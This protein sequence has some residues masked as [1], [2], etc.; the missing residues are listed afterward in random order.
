MKL[1]LRVLGLS[2]LPLI[3]TGCVRA[4]ALTAFVTDI[5]PEVQLT[6]MV[7]IPLGLGGIGLIVAFAFFPTGKKRKPETKSK[8]SLSREY[9]GE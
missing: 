6:G 3:G 8:D 9:G 7:Y 5:S 4:M 2:L 1:T